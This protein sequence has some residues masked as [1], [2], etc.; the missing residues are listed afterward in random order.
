A[1]GIAAGALLAAAYIHSSFG[2]E[3]VVEGLFE[4]SLF[5][6][7]AI[8]GFCVPLWLMLAR[9]GYDSALAAA[10]LGFVATAVFVTLTYAAGSHEQ[11]AL[12]TYTVIPY[13][14]CGAAAAL[15][16]WWVGRRLRGG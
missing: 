12:M 16:T 1:A 13:G 5:Y 4:V 10:A 15:V 11:V 2:P 3:L 9:L 14:L 6:G 7:L 8:A